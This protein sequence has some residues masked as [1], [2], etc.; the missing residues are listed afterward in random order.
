ML[1]LNKYSFPKYY[2]CDVYVV[3]QLKS[4]MKLNRNLLNKIK[5]SNEQQKSRLNGWDS[6]VTGLHKLFRK[7]NAYDL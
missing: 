3:Q 7:Q 2:V 5:R 1:P 4:L 6:T